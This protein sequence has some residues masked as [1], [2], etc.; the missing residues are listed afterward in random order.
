MRSFRDR[1]KTSPSPLGPLPPRSPPLPPAISRRIS[2]DVI[3]REE[4]KQC[5]GC[6]GEKKRQR[7]LVGGLSRKGAFLSPYFRKKR[8][9]GSLFVR[10]PSRYPPR[11]LETRT[12]LSPLSTNTKDLLVVNRL[13]AVNGNWCAKRRRRS[14]EKVSFCSLDVC[15]FSL[16]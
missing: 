3:A 15:F 12:F 8:S 13:P 7:D 16:D 9:E 6:G 14:A 1:S 10:H 5:G 2:C 11:R 4:G